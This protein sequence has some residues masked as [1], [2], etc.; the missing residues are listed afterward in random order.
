M[1]WRDLFQWLLP[2]PPQITDG[3]RFEHIEREVENNKRRIER[4]ELYLALR[5]G[6]SREH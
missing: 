6:A 3:Q 2:R 5:R 1:S 4:L